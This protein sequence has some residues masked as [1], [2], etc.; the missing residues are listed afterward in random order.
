MDSCAEVIFKGSVAWLT[1]LNGDQ[2][3]PLDLSS[4]QD[5]RRCVEE[6]RSRPGLS[7]V[8]LGS[9]GKNF[10]FGGNFKTMGPQPD[11]GRY[12]RHVTIAYHDW[13]LDFLALPVPIFS[14]IQGG[15]AG[16][17]VALGLFA[18]YVLASDDAH[19]TI[20][21]GKLGATPDGGTSFLLPRL[22]G[23]RRFQELLLTNRR[24]AAEEALQMGM[25]TE[26]CPRHE[27][28]QRT[29][30]RAALATQIPD[31]AIAATRQLLMADGGDTLRK[32]MELESRSLSARCETPEMK[33]ALLAATQQGGGTPGAINRTSK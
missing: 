1:L 24:V 18:D 12:I 11:L 19:F 16:A 10:C 23:F 30:E 32:Q 29:Q 17:G 25:V 7:A 3:N 27:L 28:E 6:I 4:V 14:A 33:R 21:F 22:V 15:S 2:G 8:V 13:L 26:V 20:A 5:L 9:R 31:G